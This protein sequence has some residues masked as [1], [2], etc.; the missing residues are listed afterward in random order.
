[1]ANE[2]QENEPRGVKNPKVIDLIYPRD[3]DIV[4]RMIEDRPWGSD[5]EQLNE[6][7]EKFNNYLDYVLDGWFIN[8][9]PAHSGKKVCIELAYVNAPGEEVGRLLAEMERFSKSV[10]L[11]FSARHILPDELNAVTAK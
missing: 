10:G 8:Q 7:G 2:L 4:L 6:L 3:N 1:M 9:Y 5:D 11:S